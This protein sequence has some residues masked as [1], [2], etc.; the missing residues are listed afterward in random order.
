MIYVFNA[1]TTNLVGYGETMSE[2]L[3]S[4]LDRGIVEAGDWVATTFPHAREPIS[5]A[6]ALTYVGLGRAQ[7]VAIGGGTLRMYPEM[8]A[9]LAGRVAADKAVVR[10]LREAQAC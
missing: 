1:V 8:V 10:A 4:V 3:N 5:L 7:L 2:A 9:A 6:E